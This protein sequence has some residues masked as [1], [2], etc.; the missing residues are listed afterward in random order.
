METTK[1]IVLHTLK[2]SDSQAVVY[3][4]TES[5][6]MI[7]AMVRRSKSSARATGN[8][9]AMQI[10]SLVEIELNYRLDRDMQNIRSVALAHTWRT[11]VYDPQKSCVSMFLGEFLHKALRRE[12]RNVNLFHFICN[13]LEWFD[14]AQKGTA[15]FHLVMM[16]SLTRFLGFWPAVDGE[17]PQGRVF[18]LMNGCYT[19]VVPAHGQYVR[20]DEAMFMPLLLKMNYMQ[21]WRVR[22]TR[23]QR[24]HMLDVIVWYYRLHVP[25]FKDLQSLKILQELF[26]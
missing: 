2:Y 13:S 16:M 12:G 18:D 8:S 6:G 17:R 21:M 1:A 14:E 19:G 20:A 11:I 15:N 10:L 23:E 22:L 3:M 5:F 25:G 4:Y 7:S 26:D 9:V 24:R